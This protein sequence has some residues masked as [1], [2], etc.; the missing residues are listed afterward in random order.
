MAEPRAA[1]TPATDPGNLQAEPGSNYRVIL[2]GRVRRI[3][4][5]AI[6]L[7]L[8]FIF[9]LPGT[10]GDLM[11]GDG[12]A[13]VQ[14]MPFWE[15]AAEQ[16][17][18]WNP[19]FWTPHLFGG[20]PLMAEP[21]AGVFHPNK[22][23]FM[24]LTPVAAL[25][26]TV[27]LYYGLAGLFTYLV[28]REEE[29]TLEASLLA[30][31]SFAFSGFLIGH[32]A[33]TALFISAASF[34][35]TFYTTRLVFRRT[36]ARAVLWGMLAVLF[37]VLNGHPQFTFYALFFAGFY[38]VYLLLRKERER[39]RRISFVKRLAAVYVLGAGLAAFQLLPTLELMLHS[40]RDK[41]TYQDFLAISLPPGS[42][43]VSLISTR[44]YHFFPN[45]GSEA[46]VDVG[47][48]VLVLALFGCW[49]ARKRA[50]FWIFLLI[51][52][53][54]LFVGDYTPLFKI[55]YRVPG[56]NLFRVASR[57]G[58][59]LD[60][61][62]AILAAFG[63]SALQ[64]R[65]RREGRRWLVALVAVLV[66]VPVVYYWAIYNSEERIFERLFQG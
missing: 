30:G 29:L 51:F 6:L 28:A 1:D 16:W 17:R 55:M 27:L 54:L 37:V 2:S 19:P 5:P 61:A 62:V 57:N 23:L 25:N 60:F 64:A 40:V 49:V 10:R 31:I 36:D 48:W 13:F 3:L 32:Q 41:L 4:Y 24:I 12:D 43:L 52:S 66:A 22:L 59:A 45:D 14:F 50:G 38:A 26:L 53:A 44:L 8:P 56:Y 15:Y 33:I 58:V 39:E 18:E 63:L 34:P 42:L 7:V 65:P 20:F 21:Q 35:V 11:L 9:F 46:M 47:V